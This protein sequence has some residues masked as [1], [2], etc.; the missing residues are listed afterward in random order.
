[1][2]RA[3]FLVLAALAAAG[4]ARA[5]DGE[6]SPWM[7]ERELRATFG[8]KDID[9]HY[10]NGET[11]SESYKTGGRIYYRD[12]VRTTGGRWSVVNGTFCTIYDDDPTGGCYRVM[13][14]GDNCYE[15][16]FVARTEEEARTPRSPDW[17]ARGWLRSE[18]ATCT[19]GENV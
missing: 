14:S 15:F 5:E 12:T 8:G 16:Y 3:A 2:R 6:V 4:V 7:S 13:K 10:P 17:T 18:A 19:S 9:G 1:M 11:F